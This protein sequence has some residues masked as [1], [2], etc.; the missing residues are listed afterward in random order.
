MRVPLKVAGVE[1]E[2]GY[3]LE[4]VPRA[5]GEEYAEEVVA[6]SAACALPARRLE[7]AALL[8]CCTYPQQGLRPVSKQ[9]QPRSRAGGGEQ[10]PA[11]VGL[12]SMARLE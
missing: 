4:E 11:H 6:K 1:V 2:A 7:P 8:S 9:Q 10:Y 3:S 12:S 5:V